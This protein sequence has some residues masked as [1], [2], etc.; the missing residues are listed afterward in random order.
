MAVPRLDFLVISYPCALVIS[1]PLGYFGGL[2]A[3]SRNGLLLKGA[4]FLDRLT[5]INTIA[6]D[7]TGTL[8]Q[9]IFRIQEIVIAE[10]S[11]WTEPSLIRLL[12]AL[13]AKSTHPLQSYP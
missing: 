1:I 6:M 10:A 11:N 13:E 5:Q 9:G 12:M 4:I 7:K 2:G 8:T 3:A